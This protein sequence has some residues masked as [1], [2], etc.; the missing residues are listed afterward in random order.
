MR[1]QV[2]QDLT[3]PWCRIG[4]HNLDAA[5]ARRA[6]SND[7]P[8]EV[9]WVPYLLDPVEP[10][11]AE[12]FQER[13]RERK[14]MTQEQIR[15]MFER[16]SEVGRSAGLTFNFDKIEVA[17]DT[18]PGHQMLALAPEE[19]QSRLL[20]ALHTAYFEYGKNIGDVAV[21]ETIATEVGLPDEA[22][23]TIRGAWA[24]DELRVELMKVVQQV[25]SA[26]INGVPFFIIDSAL[27]VNGA[28]PADVLIDAMEQ[29]KQV[30]AAT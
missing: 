26:G 8:V 25:Q 28:Q 6:E 16:V 13:L 9:E 10:G 11:S 19:T 27:G 12:P 4:K 23:Q 17:V 14:N 15:E 1:I 5:I 2:V 30:P 24:S 3:C 22:M 21:L 20:D 29:A 7:E 18:I